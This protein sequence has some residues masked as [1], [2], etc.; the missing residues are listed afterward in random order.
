MAR[1]HQ[2]LCLAG[3]AEVAAVVVHVPFCMCCSP[4]G[5]GAIQRARGALVHQRTG[6]EEGA[7][8]W[9]LFSVAGTGAS[10]SV[11]RVTAGKGWHSL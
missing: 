6:L 11:L 10:G 9:W 4:L 2:A 5:Q 8:F 7:G 3:T 1:N